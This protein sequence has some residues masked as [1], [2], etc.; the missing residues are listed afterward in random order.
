MLTKFRILLIAMFGLFISAT[1][2]AVPVETFNRT[3]AVVNGEMISLYDLDIQAAPA[4]LQANIDPKNSTS[5]AQADAVRRQ[6]LDTMIL[7]ILLRKEAERLKI[8][9]SDDEVQNELNMMMERNRNS[10]EDL[11]RR[12]AAQGLTMDMLKEKIRHSIINQRLINMM[13]YR[14][15]VVP[16][17][18]V[19]K[20][21]DEHPGAFVKDRALDVQL[22]V[23]DKK[24][25]SKKIAEKIKN[26]TL[27]F[28]DA[29]K[30]HSVGPR[31]K[32]GGRMGTIYWTE[33]SQ[34]W[35]QMIMG[36]RPGVLSSIFDLDGLDAVLRV[37]SITPGSSL[38]LEEAMPQIEE[39]LKQPLIEARFNEY[40]AQLRNKAVI[41]VRY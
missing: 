27:S 8:T 26:G 24:T 22:I 29:A 33:L 15:I 19:V 38:S 25:D 41:D 23:F 2:R 36:L 37:N 21:Y 18:D 17:E 12:L 32:E 28:D 35:Q 1:A 14:K 9:V 6:V 11:Q 40:V 10:K 30:A 4:L 39:Y 5:K 3:V 16:K 7:D 31:A 34:E 20:F 13:I